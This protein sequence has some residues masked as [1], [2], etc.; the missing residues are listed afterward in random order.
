MFQKPKIYKFSRECPAF[1]KHK[2]AKHH[3]KHLLPV[4]VLWYSNYIK[5]V[6]MGQA[7]DTHRQINAFQQQIFIERRLWTPGSKM[8]LS[9]KA[10]A[11]GQYKAALRAVQRFGNHWGV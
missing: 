3:W 4:R 6:E 7:C 11:F 8:V 1:V 9:C 5:K 10:S 2:E